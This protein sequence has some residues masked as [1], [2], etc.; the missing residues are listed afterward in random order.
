MKHEEVT[1]KIIAA[2]YRVFNQLGFGFVESVYKKAMV[3]CWV[4]KA[5]RQARLLQRFSI[6][7]SA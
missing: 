4:E 2:A 1:H 7:E 5:I 6:P 3:R